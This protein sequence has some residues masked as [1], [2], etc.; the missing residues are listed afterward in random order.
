MAAK[1][2]PVGSGPGCP[3]GLD[4]LVRVVPVYCS[5]KDPDHSHPSKIVFILTYSPIVV[6]SNFKFFVAALSGKA[7]RLCQLSQRESHWHIGS[8]YAN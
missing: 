2:P 5:R 3:Y 6:N 7:F 4:P 8:V 1:T